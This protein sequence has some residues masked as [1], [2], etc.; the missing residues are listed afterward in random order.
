MPSRA[1]T[2]PAGSRQ[3]L[4]DISHYFLSDPETAL[5]LPSETTLLPIIVESAEKDA[6]VYALA[7]AIYSQGIQLSVLHLDTL[8]Q[9][10][11]PRSSSLY[12]CESDPVG[13]KD[14]LITLSNGKPPPAACLLPACIA[15][16]DKLEGYER[17][18]LFLPERMSLLHVAYARIKRLLLRSSS[19][20]IGVILSQS[21]GQKQS[22][23]FFHRLAQ[24]VR[25]FMGRDIVYLGFARDTVE[26]KGKIERNSSN[27]NNHENFCVIVQHMIEAGFLSAPFLPKQEP[28]AGVLGS[29]R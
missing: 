1:V 22:Q 7:R 9:E 16:I 14:L 21:L 19:L 4:D 12:L 17:A 6:L 11:D 26:K 20:S 8:L 18:V 28:A 3:R 23:E 13:V 27:D 15:E 2:K 25:R 29:A 24:A 10:R 5:V